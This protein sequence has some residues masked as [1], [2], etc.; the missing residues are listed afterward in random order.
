MGFGKVIE[1]KYGPV[2]LPENFE[3]REAFFEEVEKVFLRM[4]EELYQSK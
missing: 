3:T 4:F 1:Y 2:I